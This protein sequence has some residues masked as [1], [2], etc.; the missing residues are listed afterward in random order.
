VPGFG[1]GKEF[2]CQIDQNQYRKG[3]RI[4]DL[5][6]QKLPP[7]NANTP[8]QSHF[9]PGILPAKAIRV[10]QVRQSL[11][12][13]GA[14]QPCDDE[15]KDSIFFW[16]CWSLSWAGLVNDLKFHPSKPPVW[17]GDTMQLTLR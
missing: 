16:P 14:V 10:G 5:I 15:I 7:A 3:G 9:S 1:P 12:A 6:Q 4:L 17:Q 13:A 11:T 8:K 2:V